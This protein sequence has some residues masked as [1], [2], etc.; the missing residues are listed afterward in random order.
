LPLEITRMQLKNLTENYRIFS[1]YNHLQLQ[2]KEIRHI[3]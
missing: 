2:S 3:K 1:L